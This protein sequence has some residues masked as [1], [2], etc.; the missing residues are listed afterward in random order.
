MAGPAEKFP[1]F[2][3]DP[4]LGKASLA[5]ILPLT[6]VAQQSISATGLVD[7]GAAINV[8]PYSLGVDLRFD[9]N[10][11]TKSVALSGNRAKIEARV[12][13]VSALIGSFAPVRL[14]FAW[15]C[16]DDVSVILG[17]VNFFLEFDVCLFR[18]RET[19]EVRPRQMP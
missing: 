3:R 16:T 13:V 4:Q 17:Q 7:S 14:A 9:W 18:A 15:A 2:A 10:A 5:P 12:V 19:F 8:L 11:Q 1:Y 6:L